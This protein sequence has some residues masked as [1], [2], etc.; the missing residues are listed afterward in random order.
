M[1]N[2]PPQPLAE[3]DLSSLSLAHPA[4]PQDPV[5]HSDCGDASSLPVIASASLPPHLSHSPLNNQ[6]VSAPFQFGSRHLLPTSSVYEFNAWDHVPP[7]AAELARA[8]AQYAAQRAHPVSAFDAERFNSDPARWWNRFYTNNT[9]NF[10]KDRKW[11]QQEFPVLTEL[12]AAGR[13]EDEEQ[14]Q[15]PRETTAT[16]LEVGAGAGNTA[17]PLLK[18]NRNPGLMIHACDFSSKA[19]D[20]LRASPEY[21]ERHMRASVWDL[22]GDELPP[23]VQPNSIDVVLLIFVFSALSPRQWARAVRNVH[24]VL[25]PGGE[26]C[27]RDYGRGDLAQV[28]FRKGRWMEENFYV[29]GDG[30]RVYFFDEAELHRIWGGEPQGGDA[31]DESRPS[32]DDKANTAQDG[33]REKTPDPTPCEK[34]HATPPPPPPEPA[35]ESATEPNSP[36]PSSSHDRAQPQPEES[37]RFEIVS[38]GADRRLLVNRQKQLQMHRCWLQ[39]RFRKP[40]VGVGG[41]DCRSGR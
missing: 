10:F 35:P 21:D 30:T 33:I 2:P 14:E 11:L 41:M 16:I 18:A 32:E 26:V 13:E 4:P 1:L 36:S 12:T 25:K 23:E 38:L 8:D 7:P 28:R 31:S 17:F 24:A 15:K 22:A 29:R 3:P 27:F 40:S 39:G 6:K 34:T 5:L 37:P 20:L 9:A 19:V